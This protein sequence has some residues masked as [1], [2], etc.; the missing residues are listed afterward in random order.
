MKKLLILIAVFIVTQSYAQQYDAWFQSDTLI[1]GTDTLVTDTAKSTTKYI[2]LS[3]A[4]TGATYTDSVA[5]EIYDEKLAEWVRVGLREVLTYT[6][7]SLASPG[8]GTTKMYLVL[9]AGL[10]KYTIIRQRLL[11]AQY[12]AGRRT[13]TSWRF[14]N[15]F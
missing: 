7:Y 11:N 2:Y 9:Y 4:D 8:A 13:L 3:V 5:V 15:N 10:S 12:V 6:D 14:V 1:A